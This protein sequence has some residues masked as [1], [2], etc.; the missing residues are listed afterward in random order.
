MAT[1]NGKEQRLRRLF[2]FKSMEQGRPS[3]SACRNPDQGTALPHSRP[4]AQPLHHYYFYIRDEVLGPMV[5][6]VASSFPSG[7][8]IT[9]TAT[10]SS[11]RNS[12]VL[13]TGFRKNDN[14]FLAVND[15]AALQ[16][17]ADRLSLEIIATARL[18][19]PDPGTEVSAKERSSSPVT[20]LRYQPIEYCRNFTLKRNFPIHKLFERSCELGLWRPPPTRSPRFSAPACTAGTAASSPPLSIRSS[21]AIM[22]SAPISRLPS[23]SSMRSSSRS[24]ATNSAPTTLPTS[25]SRRVGPSRC[26][27]QTFQAITD[28][29]AGFQAQWPRPRHFPLL[30]RIALPITIGSVRYPGIKIHDRRVIR[31][32]EVILHAGSH[33]GGWTA[34]QSTRPSSPPSISPNKRMASINSRRSAQAKGHGLIERDGSRYAYRLTPKGVQVALLFLFFHNRLCGPLA[35]SRFHHEPDPKHRPQS[36]L[37]TAYHRADKAIQQ[38]VELLAAA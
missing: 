1:S 18:L 11:S 31:L 6:R 19:D 13:Q 20:L 29:F 30:Q 28:R 32:C 3:A 8:P 35:N 26:S 27:R 22:S 36:Q 34:K 14:A 21:M 17:V 5:M 9:S 37:E 33:L 12:T 10:A 38:I 24:C 7:P 16:A 25:V 15:V 4:P 23:S 2:V